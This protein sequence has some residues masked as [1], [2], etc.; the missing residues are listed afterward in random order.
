MTRRHREE[1]FSFSKENAR[2]A[3]ETLKKYPKGREQ[4]ALLPLLEMA[5]RQNGGWLSKEVIA[6]IAGYLGLSEMKVWEVAS[7]YT[8]FHLEPKGT[9]HIQICG[10][11]PCW[12]CGSGTLMKT[13][14]KWLG[15]EVGETTADGKFSLSEVECLGACTKAPVIQVNDDYVENLDDKGLVKLLETLAEE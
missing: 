8:L 4:S 6:Y 10:T 1:G 13:A 12:L 9:H 15:I 3:Q 5:Q 2:K 11:P 7:F 14:K